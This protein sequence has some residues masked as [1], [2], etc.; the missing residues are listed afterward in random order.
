MKLSIV[1][2]AYNEEKR[3]PDSLRK[4]HKYLSK[5]PYDYE[6]IVVNDASK[7]KTA[8][9]VKKLIP[10]IQGL[11]LINNQVNLG[12]GGGVK[13]GILNAK[14]DYVVYTDADDSTS[15]DHL[16]KAWPYLEK[17]AKIV[18]GTRDKRDHPDAKQSVSQP[19]WKRL[20]GDLGNLMIQAL[21]LPGIWDTQCGF[22]IFEKGFG[23]KLFRLSKGFRWAFDIEII[24]LAKNMKQEVVIIPIN[25]I[26]EAGSTFKIKG[27]IRFF[28][29]FFRIFWNF[30]TRQ[31]KYEE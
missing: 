8:E 26:D 1:I 23:Q 7:D 22:K 21:L 30:L 12:K 20:M 17:G 13:N 4:K 3:L 16:E 15:M 14:G 25:W 2:S 9:V 5:Q 6:I 24:K 11:R 27:Y 18:I 19:I 28:K 31:Y 29:E 10:E